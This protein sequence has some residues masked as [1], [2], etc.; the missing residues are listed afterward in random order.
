MA[1]ATDGEMVAAGGHRPQRRDDLVE[2]AFGDELLLVD[3]TTARQH[4]LNATAAA[5]WELAD[6]TR[7][8][9][10]LAGAL[11]AAYGIDVDAVDGPVREVLAGLAAERALR[12][13]VEPPPREPT[14]CLGC[15]DRSPP[16]PPSDPLAA[17]DPDAPWRH[18]LG[19]FRCGGEVVDIHLDDDDLA[20]WLADAL[21]PLAVGADDPA[22][23]PVRRR[24][25]VLA[26]P[27]HPDRL[28]VDV[29]GAALVAADPARV[30]TVLLGDLTAR[31]V[32][33]VA[34]IPV[35][36]A[37]SAI[38]GGTVLLPGRSGS[39]K[40]TLVGALAQRGHAYLGDEV[41]ALGG[42]GGVVTGHPRALGLQ[43]EGVRALGLDPATLSAPDE[44]GRH[45]LDPARLGAE[46]R[47][48]GGPVTVVV[49]PERIAGADLQLERLE[50]IDAASRLV[51]ELFRVRMDR[52]AVVALAEVARQVPCHALVYGSIDDAGPWIEGLARPG[53]TSPGR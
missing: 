16:P 45:H 26:V 39:G 4:R 40:S 52:A 14:P 30:R 5:I 49:F 12:Q 21:A 37:A 22:D 17:R 11:A 9:T 1:E 36:A 7:T 33:T 19:P 24:Y 3:L 47:V 38:D 28:H 10:E 50:P 8:S 41:V 27:E 2:L 25:R 13:P 31:A 18:H 29:D 20:A 34:G 35:H 46:G 15:G 48:T 53:A 23:E 6:G 43:A 51:R 42:E 32:A 44:A